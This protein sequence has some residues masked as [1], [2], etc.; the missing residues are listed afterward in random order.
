MNPSRLSCFALGPRLPWRT[1]SPLLRTLP[2]VPEACTDCP[3]GSERRPAH[4][5]PPRDTAGAA[6]RQCCELGRLLS[7]HGVS[8][9]SLLASLEV[10]KHVTTKH[11]TLPLRLSL[12]SKTPALSNAYCGADVCAGS[13]GRPS[14]LPAP[15]ARRLCPAWR[16]CW[17][18]QLLPSGTATSEQEVHVPQRKLGSDAPPPSFKHTQASI[19]NPLAAVAL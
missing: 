7:A 1:L 8:P 12:P 5:A 4:S 14:R 18:G 17:Q 15:P 2:A 10:T 3:A 6:N 13:A 19:R 9:N 16:S 11:V